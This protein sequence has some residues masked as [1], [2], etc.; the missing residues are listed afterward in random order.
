MTYHIFTNSDVQLIVWSSDSD[1]FTESSTWAPPTLLRNKLLHIHKNTRTDLWQDPLFWFL[2]IRILYY[3]VVQ[4]ILVFAT[5]WSWRSRSWGRR[6][7]YRLQVCEDG[8]SHDQMRS[9]LAGANKVHLLKRDELW[10]RLIHNVKRHL[11]FVLTL[12]NI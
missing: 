2:L 4:G 7:G 11:Q 5:V 12:L 6:L 9:H 1:W 10:I 8:R 3:Q